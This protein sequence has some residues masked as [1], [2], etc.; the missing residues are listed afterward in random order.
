MF[1]RAADRSPHP[2]ADSRQVRAAYNFCF[3]HDN[4]RALL[5][6]TFYTAKS[7]TLM[8]STTPNSDMRYL[9]RVLISHLS[10]TFDIKT[11][12]YSAVEVNK[13]FPNTL[14]E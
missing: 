3:H 5:L 8:F 12:N 11:I 4:V 9:G 6:T 7:S 10:C 2:M 13:M 1:Q 14:K